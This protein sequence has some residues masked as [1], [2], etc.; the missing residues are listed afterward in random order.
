MK[1]ACT[2]TT[3]GYMLAPRINAAGRMGSAESALR[4]LQTESPSEGE[5]LGQFLCSCNLQRQL[6]EE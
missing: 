2:V 3:V 6:E 4:L 1:S 5:A